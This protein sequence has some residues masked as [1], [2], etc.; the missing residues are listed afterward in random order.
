MDEATIALTMMTGLLLAIFLGLLV[1]GA[2]SGQF[3]NVEEAKY[4]IFRRNNGDES[5]K[6]KNPEPAEKK[7][8]GGGAL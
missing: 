8:G 6:A 3:K 5:P 1:W 7:E 4:Q 2:R